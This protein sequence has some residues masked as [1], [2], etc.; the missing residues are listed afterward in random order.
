M[1]GIQNILFVDRDYHHNTIRIVIKD[2]SSSYSANIDTDA[3][4]YAFEH[5]LGCLMDQVC[6]NRVGELF[7]EYFS[8][9]DDLRSVDHDKMVAM[10]KALWEECA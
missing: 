6:I 10:L 7:D 9:N 4:V 1:T 3:L 8:R 2:N 5:D